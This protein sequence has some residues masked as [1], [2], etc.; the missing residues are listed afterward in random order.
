MYIYLYFLFIF[1][2]FLLDISSN[3]KVK[4]IFFFVLE[5][6]KNIMNNKNIKIYSRTIQATIYVKIL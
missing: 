2:F 6:F 5:W 3:K 1:D 4:F